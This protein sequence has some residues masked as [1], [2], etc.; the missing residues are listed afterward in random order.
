M[1]TTTALTSALGIATLSF[2]LLGCT[3]AE[4]PAPAT[5]DETPAAA[6]E[7]QEEAPA[8]PAAAEGD[9]S[10]AK[11][12]STPGELLTTIPGEG[13]SIDVYQVGTAAATKTGQFATPDGTPIISPGDELVF[14]NF[15]VTNTSSETVPASIS[16]VN[17][18]PRYDDWPYL[19]GMD[20]VVD[21][22]LFDAFGIHTSPLALG[23]QAPLQWEPGTRYSQAVNF[24]YQPGSPLTIKATFTP[25]KADGSLDH[26]KRTEVVGSTVI[27]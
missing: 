12:V 18:S 1:R 13:F 21:Q 3:A 9:A 7:E 10:F 16:L 17:I 25:A 4:E 2:A 15:V 6:V 19:G 11:P 14:V 22:A 20:S 23:N 5:A 8:G 26:D 27:K 24:L